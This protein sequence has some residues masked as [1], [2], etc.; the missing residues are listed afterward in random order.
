MTTTTLA[1]A[2]APAAEPDL[3]LTGLHE[4]HTEATQL[5]IT[6]V[7]VRSGWIDDLGDPRYAEG[8]RVGIRYAELE[9]KFNQ[10]KP[11][12]STRARNA[13]LRKTFR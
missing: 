9:E 6:L 12:G 5:G 13:Q 11:A 8:Y 10:R 7:A 2:S 3:F 4:G 1:P